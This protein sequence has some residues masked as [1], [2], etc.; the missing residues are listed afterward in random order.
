MKRAV[1][2]CG[3]F[4]IP[5]DMKS[6]LRFLSWVLGAWAGFSSPAH[7]MFNPT[8]IG[9]GIIGGLPVSA[10][11]DISHHL[12]MVYQKTSQSMCTGTLI[13]PQ[14]VLTA[15]H[16]IEKNYADLLVTFG[17]NPMSGSYIPHCVTKVIPHPQFNGSSIDQR[18]DLAL[19]QFS[20]A[21]PQDSVPALLPGDDF[22]LSQGEGFTAAGFG[23]TNS[24]PASE[25][26]HDDSGLLRATDLE[27]SSISDDGKQFDVDQTDGHGVCSGDSGGPALANYQGQDYVMGVAS[28]VAWAKAETPADENVCNQFSIYMNI[29]AY[30]PWINDSLKQLSQ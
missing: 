11:S 10:Q 12:V 5:V 9:F 20:G 18:N 23:R 26:G 16:C 1:E 17:N 13:A 19:V 14:V 30:S 6:Q 21:A 4:A 15:A 7:A 8:L 2:N 28:A 29:K 3:P 22:P 27:I 25:G 24:T